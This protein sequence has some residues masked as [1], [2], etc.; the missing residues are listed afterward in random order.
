MTALFD[1]I[2]MG[3][4]TL[5]N[6]AALAPM[7]RARCPGNTPTATPRAITRSARARG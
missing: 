6:R 3:G 4:L 5:K 7:T 1:P 2:R